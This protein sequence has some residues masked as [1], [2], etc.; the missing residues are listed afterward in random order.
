MTNEVFIDE[1]KRIHVIFA[2]PTLIKNR[3]SVLAEFGN[4]NGVIVIMNNG[5]LSGLMFNDMRILRMQAKLT[6]ELVPAIKIAEGLM[7]NE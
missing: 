7:K 3:L 1:Y 2:E 6:R 5:K 4:V